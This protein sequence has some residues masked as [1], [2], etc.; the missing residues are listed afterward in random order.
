MVGGIRR[1]K[2]DIWLRRSQYERRKR[3]RREEIGETTC[4]CDE[5]QNTR[6]RETVLTIKTK[7]KYYFTKILNILLR[8]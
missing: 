4:K 5:T 1:M 2:E 8:L 7:S 3:G 6:N